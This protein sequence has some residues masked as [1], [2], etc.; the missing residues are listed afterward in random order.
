MSFSI[1]G[2]F[3]VELSKGGLYILGKIQLTGFNFFDVC[4]HTFL[5][6]SLQLGDSTS[7]RLN[8]G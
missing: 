8:G 7:E 2:H 3:L 1:S 4:L 5:N 6:L